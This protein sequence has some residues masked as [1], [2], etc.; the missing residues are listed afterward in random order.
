MNRKLLMTAV[1][2]G[3]VISE[4][5]LSAQNTA[6]RLT[7]GNAV[8]DVGTGTTPGTAL[9]PTTTELSASSSSAN[10]SPSGGPGAIGQDQLFGNW[11]WYR[12]NGTNTR[13]LS[14]RQSSGTAVRTTL[15]TNSVNYA[16]TATTPGLLFNLSFTLTDQ[17]GAGTNAANVTSSLSVTNNTGATVDMALFNYADYFLFGQD[18]NDR[19]RTATSPGVGIVGDRELL[20]S[21]SAVAAAA[22]TLAHKGFGASGYGVGTFSGI[23][24][25][26]SDTGIDNFNDLNSSAPVEPA[27]GSDIGG[28]FQWNT[29]PIL[30]GATFTAT[31]AIAVH[32][33]G[34]AVPMIPE[35]TGIAIGGILAFGMLARRRIVV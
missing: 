26:L 12:V 11:W 29:G 14:V 32:L 9:I 19:L 27:A 28:V 33:S 4:N 34:T 31:S 6:I 7:D 18:A 30:N 25:Q 20:I 5:S 21:D 15:G 23:G 16:I 17:D 8:Y 1:I 24:G 10:F 2:T 13:E 3:L 22:A 35:P